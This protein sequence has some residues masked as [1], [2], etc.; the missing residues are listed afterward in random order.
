MRKINQRGFGAIEGLLI[1]IALTLIV[2]VGY[3]V[4]HTQKGADKTL[5]EAYQDDQGKLYQISLLATTDDQKQLG[6]AIDA[7]CHSQ[8]TGAMN[9][10]GA[11]SAPDLFTNSQK[12]TITSTSATINM[13][14]YDKKSTDS[15]WGGAASYT[16]TKENGTWKYS[17]A[18]QQ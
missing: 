18:G 16:F 7:Y 9:S 10:V 13:A 15:P 6:T 3:Y 1:I 14:C 2:F 17:S 8:D 11:V 12:A 4:W 5:D